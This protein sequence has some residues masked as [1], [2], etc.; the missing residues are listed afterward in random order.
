MQDAQG[1]NYMISFGI[2]V[3]A[4]TPVLAAIYFLIKFEWPVFH[5]KVALLPGM[6]TVLVAWQRAAG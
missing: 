4:V 2:G 6:H 3:L 5:V 1:I